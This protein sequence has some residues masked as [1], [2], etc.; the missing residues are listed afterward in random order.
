MR[1]CRLIFFSGFGF[2]DESGLFGE[3]LP[4]CDFCVAGFSLGAIRAFEFVV[5]AAERIDRLILLSP[6]FFE[7]KDDRFRRLQT[8]AFARDRSAYMERFYALCGGVDPRWR[9]PD[10]PLDDLRLLLNFAWDKA[11]LKNI[12]RIGVDVI[13]GGKDNIIDSPAAM[14]FFVECGF[15]V[16]YIKQANHLLISED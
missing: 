7:N 6:A 15:N 12:G 11:A 16:K 8:M 2:K 5:S 10:P 4:E 14:E 3:F 1:V 13:I 9:D